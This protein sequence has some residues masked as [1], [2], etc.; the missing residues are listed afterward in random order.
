MISKS[1]PDIGLLF[2]IGPAWVHKISHSILKKFF[3]IE[4]KCTMQNVLQKSNKKKYL[5]YLFQ[6]WNNFQFIYFFDVVGNSFNF[7]SKMFVYNR[8]YSFFLLFI[9]N[10]FFIAPPLF[11]C[12]KF[13]KICEF[14]LGLITFSIGKISTPKS[15]NV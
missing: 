8:L 3:W 9:V 1:I 10:N 5:K 4:L 6:I 13:L 11:L 14:Y 2:W 15:K 12:R 7:Y